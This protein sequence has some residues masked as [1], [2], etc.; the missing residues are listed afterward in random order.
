[1]APIGT[2]CDRQR[3]RKAVPF[4]WKGGRL[5]MTAMLNTFILIALLLLSSFFL[6]LRLSRRLPERTD[7]TSVY[8]LEAMT[9]FVK[10][11]LHELTSSN[12]TD[13]G[14][15]EEEYRRRKSKRAELKKALRGCTSGDLRDK[16]YVKE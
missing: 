5:A 9:T 12:L 16:E 10:A 14:L 13:F 2:G 1:G 11:T 8:T 7:D 4:R 3:G 15:S 6:Y